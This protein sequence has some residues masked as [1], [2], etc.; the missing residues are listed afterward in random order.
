MTAQRDQK[1][2]VA[3]I[4]GQSEAVS[5]ELGRLLDL[6]DSRGALLLIAGAT[7]Q[8][9]TTTA[10]V[11]MNEMS[12]AEDPFQLIDD[13]RD[14]ADV[15][16]AVALALAGVKVV[17]TINATSIERLRVLLRYHGVGEV[18]LDRL[19]AEGRALFVLQELVWADATWRQN[20]LRIRQ[21]EVQAAI[22]AG[23]HQ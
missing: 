11:V 2:E 6:T 1:P 14:G 23:S 12:R 5:R 21:S 15:F 22:Q 19:L 20:S 16:Q 8:G 10:N 17:A 3:S 4:F 18:L 9:K 13:L 7:W